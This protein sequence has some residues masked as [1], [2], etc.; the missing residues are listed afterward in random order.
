MILN[1]KNMATQD[2]AYGV[3]S[4]EARRLLPFYLH[5]KAKSWIA[6]LDAISSISA[7]T[8]PGLRI[9]KLKGDRKEQWS[10]RI[11]RQ[12]RICFFWEESY[13]KEVEIVDYH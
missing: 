4:K 7:L 5:K 9:E 13:A 2:I 12:Y 10:I 11:N 6:I 8:S 3:N 1:F